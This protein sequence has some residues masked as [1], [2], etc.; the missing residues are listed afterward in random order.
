MGVRTLFAKN[1][2]FN[3]YNYQTGSVWPHDNAIIALGAE[4]VRIAHDISMVASYLR[5]NHLPEMH[6]AAGGKK[7][8]FP[9]FPMQYIG[10]NTPQ[11]CAAGSALMLTQAIL[12]L[13]PDAPRNICFCPSAPARRLTARLPMQSSHGQRRPH[14]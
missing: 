9:K 14:P 11:A 7:N 6:S 13:L 2:T 12:G 3:P 8:K 10:T 5:L 1:P 4:A